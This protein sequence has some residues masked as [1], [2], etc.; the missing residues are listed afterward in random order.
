MPWLFKDESLRLKENADGERTH[1]GNEFHCV[2]PVK[3]KKKKLSK[4]FRFCHQRCA[5][6]GCV[7]SGVK[8][9]GWIVH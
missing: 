8:L 5:E 1:Y 9:S 7:R 4:D 3:K 2:G 6:G